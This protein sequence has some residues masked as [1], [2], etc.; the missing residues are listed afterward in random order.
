MR[1][2][3]L[4]PLLALAGCQTI[5]VPTCEQVLRAAD[6]VEEIAALLEARGIEPESAAKVARYVRE[7]RF[8]VTTACGLMG[9]Q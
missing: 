7:G 1:A 4:A 6:T 3:L 9:A 5:S 2:L 8:A